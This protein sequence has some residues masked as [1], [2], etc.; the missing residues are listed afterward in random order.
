MKKIWK[1]GD[2]ELQRS[3]VNGYGIQNLCEYAEQEAKKGD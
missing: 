2:K 1:G 3:D